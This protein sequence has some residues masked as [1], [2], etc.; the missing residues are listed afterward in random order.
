MFARLFFVIIRWL[1]CSLSVFSWIVDGEHVWKMANNLWYAY[2]K[3]SGNNFFLFGVRSMSFFSSLQHVCVYFNANGFF[4]SPSLHF[5]IWMNGTHIVFSSD[6][7]AKKPIWLIL[8]DVCVWNAFFS[9]EIF[10]Q[11]VE[12]IQPNGLLVCIHL[13]NIRFDLQ[14]SPFFSTFYW[15]N[16]EFS[17]SFWPTQTFVDGIHWISVEFYSGM[18]SNK[19]FRSNWHKTQQFVFQMY[20]N[21]I[22]IWHSCKVKGSGISKA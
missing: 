17:K 8:I 11:T 4:L 18:L 19:H 10:M 22:N 1:L 15:I 13:V 3:F 6:L 5:F 7:W 21:S 16:V 2:L 20:T 12:I 9:M 14:K